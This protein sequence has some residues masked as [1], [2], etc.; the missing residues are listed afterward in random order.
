V[1]VYV[2]V[3]SGASASG[4]MRASTRSYRFSARPFLKK[5]PILH[6]LQPSGSAPDFVDPGNQPILFDL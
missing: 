3:E 6:A 5:T 1:S 2:L 4:Q